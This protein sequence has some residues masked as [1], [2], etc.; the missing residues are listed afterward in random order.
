MPLRSGRKGAVTTTSRQWRRTMAVDPGAVEV[1]MTYAPVAA[2][3]GAVAGD[4]LLGVNDPPASAFATKCHDD[5]GIMIVAA[6][7]FRLA[8]YERRVG[9]GAWSVRRLPAAWPW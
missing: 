7:P 9:G 2:I 1:R 3:S 5:A 4:R 8:A 6:R